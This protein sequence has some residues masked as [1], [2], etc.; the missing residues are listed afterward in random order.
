MKNPIFITILLFALV[1]CSKKKQIQ[2]R[3]VNDE[4]VQSIP[5]FPECDIDLHAFMGQCDSFLKEKES[6]KYY[7]ALESDTFNYFTDNMEIFM[8]GHG[9]F[10]P[11]F[12]DT[13]DLIV[14]HYM[15]EP[16][17]KRMLRI[18]LVEV[19]YKNEHDLNK[20]LNK[21]ILRMDVDIPYSSHKLGLSQYHDYITISQDELL[22]LNASYEYSQRDFLHLV[23]ILKQNINT[24]KYV[25]KILC[26]FG[27]D[28]TTENVP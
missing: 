1:C 15:Y 25:G 20:Q 2:E 13:T 18:Y 10:M 12:L 26:L 27:A 17:T 28:C 24:N 9:L 23:E 7:F 22:W 8:Y 3:I 16:N 11:L 21:L 4:I 14:R 19:K 6:E 5:S